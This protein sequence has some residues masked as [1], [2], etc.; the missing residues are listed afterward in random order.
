MCNGSMGIRGRDV[1]WLASDAFPLSVASLKL[2]NHDDI[3]TV[4][5]GD[6]MGAS[7]GLTGVFPP[8]FRRTPSPYGHLVR[9]SSGSSGLGLMAEWHGDIGR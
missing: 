3:S 8:T 6:G 1:I 9:S 7:R 2:Q 4:D 5:C